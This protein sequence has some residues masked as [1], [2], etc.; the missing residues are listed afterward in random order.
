MT[1]IICNN[2]E[3]AGG[4]IID[5]LTISVYLDES[6]TIAEDYREIKRELEIQ[7]GLSIL[8]FTFCW[9]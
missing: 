6:N 3:T 9:A 1:K 4:Y 5:E 2:I 7:L 8:K